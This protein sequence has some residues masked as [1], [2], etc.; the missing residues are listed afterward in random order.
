MIKSL[1]G[2]QKRTQTRAVLSSLKGLPMFLRVEPSVKTLGYF[3][4]TQQKALNMSKFNL[5][6]H[7]PYV[8]LADL[9]FET[10]FSR[11]P[12]ALFAGNTSSWL[13]SSGV[14]ELIVPEST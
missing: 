9:L 3:Q 1:Q 7:S 5:R 10:A 2:R 4:K 14:N 12:F 8:Q 6:T 11:V 13:I